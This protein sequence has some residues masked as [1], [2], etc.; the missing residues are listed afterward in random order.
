MKLRLA[1]DYWINSGFFTLLRNISNILL[2]FGGFYFLVRILD[3]NTFGV[4][5]LFTGTTTLIE[6]ARNGLVSN[7]FLKY[8]SSSPEEE[9]PKI[10]TAS[11]VV[12]G[13]LTLFFIAVNCAIAGWLSRVWHMPAVRDLFYTF[14]LVFVL[15]GFIN[16]LNIIQQ[17]NL[18]FKGTYLSSL[19]GAAIMFG[20]IFACFLLH[21]QFSLVSLI[22]VQFAGA[23]VNLIIAYS[24]TR[25]YL[26]FSPRVEGKWVSKLIHYGKFS[27]G[28]MI[29]SIIFGN[30]DQWMLGYMLSPIAA[31]VYNIATRITSLVEVPTGTVATIVFPQSAKRMVSEGPDA[32]RYLYEKSVGTI[33]AILLPGLLILFLFPGFFVQIIAGSNYADSI[34]VLRVTVLYCLLI[35]YGRQSGTI[36]DSIGM[37]QTNF[38][39][40]IFSACC[41]VLTNFFFISH[42]GIVGAAYGTFTASLVN[43]CLCQ[44]I[45]SKRLNVRFLNTLKYALDF[46]PRTVSGLRALRA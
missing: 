27:F 43:F 21:R 44:Y 24:Y 28:T 33:L 9:H 3:K 23:V 11:M 7:A 15:T 1:G 39:I 37:P 18:K 41:N 35:P 25:R 8:L 14:N 10:I 22:F 6:F 46:Y 19:A 34:P 26:A 32:A 30:I 36:L 12:T 16:Q 31:G 17:A 40:V 42:Y 45:L 20:Y 13:L 29:S 5:C 4:W 38:Y 2:G